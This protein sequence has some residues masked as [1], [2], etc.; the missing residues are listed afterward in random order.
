MPR[1]AETL[2]IALND[3]VNAESRLYRLKRGTVL[4][5]VPGPSLLGRSAAIWCNYPVAGKDLS[6][7]SIEYDLS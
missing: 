5:L 2:S 1:Q 7:R 3:G 4:R 6:V